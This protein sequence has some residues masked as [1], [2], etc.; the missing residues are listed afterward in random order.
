MD[1]SHAEVVDYGCGYGDLCILTSRAGA[2]RVAAVD[3]D[4][5]CIG[6]LEEKMA[7]EILYLVIEPIQ[8]NI[9]KFALNMVDWGAYDYGYCF[10]VL[11]YLIARDRKEFLRNAVMQCDTLFLECQ[12]AGDGPGFDFVH[13]D[14]D[15]DAWLT[16]QGILNKKIGQ[17]KVKE[18]LFSRSIWMCQRGLS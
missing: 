4:P 1:L 8:T 7:K 10:S 13:K 17:T 11:P 12:Y 6:I 9:I 18:G 2:R 15:M 5:Y 16:E 3:I 14:A